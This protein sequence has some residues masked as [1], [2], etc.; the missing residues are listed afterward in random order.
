VLVFERAGLVFAFN[1]HP[2]NS[3]A[4]YRIGAGVPGEYVFALCLT[5]AHTRSVVC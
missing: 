4:D 3:F 2:T 1:F 5:C